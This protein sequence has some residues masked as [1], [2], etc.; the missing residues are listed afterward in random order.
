M[1]ASPESKTSRPITG[2]P[3]SSDLSNHHTAPSCQDKPG[4]LGEFNVIFGRFPGVSLR[5]NSDFPFVDALPSRPGVLTE[6]RARAV[7]TGDLDT[8]A[9][10]A[11][12]GLPTGDGAFGLEGELGV[13]AGDDL[14]FD[15]GGDPLLL[16]HALNGLTYGFGVLNLGLRGSDRTGELGAGGLGLGVRP[17]VWEL[18]SLAV[19]E[20]DGTV[21]RAMVLQVMLRVKLW[22]SNQSM[23]RRDAP[24]IP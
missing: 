22:L 13:F 2:Y 11:F 18:A 15:L 16:V 5:I 21:K 23:R 20:I 6:D 14:A 12:L 9:D 8:A 10:L 17:R 7:L 24:E 19:G 4:E 1:A 3:N